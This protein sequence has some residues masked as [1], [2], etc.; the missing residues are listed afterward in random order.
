MRAVVI[1]KPGARPFVQSLARPA[2]RGGEALVRARAFSICG[3]DL[4][5]VDGARVEPFVSYPVVP[6]H[7]WSGTVVELGPGAEGRLQLDEQVVAEG[8]RGCHRCRACRAYAP[9]LCVLGYSEIGFTEPGG[10]AEYVAVPVERLHRLPEAIPLSAAV[11]VEP[12][13]VAVRALQAASFTAGESIAVIGAGALGLLILQV[14]AAMGANRTIAI[15]R[16]SGTLERALRLGASAAIRSTEPGLRDSLKD[17]DVLVEAA[18]A[19]AAVELTL[20]LAPVASRVVLAGVTG[21]SLPITVASDLF[22][23][24]G[25]SV[26]GVAGASPESWSKAISMLASTDVD[27]EPLITDRYPVSEADDAFERARVADPA[28]IRVVLEHDWS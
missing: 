9:A 26:F 27:L 28:V 1:E 11:L 23:F 15:S 5:I 17:V 25:L 16:S 7:E 8:I 22:V 20:A 10:G 19:A 12:A 4:E 21:S 6:G 3:S 2:V 24:N 14:A 18:G 13:A